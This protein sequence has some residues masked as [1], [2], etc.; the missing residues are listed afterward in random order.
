[1]DFCGVFCCCFVCF[2]F[3]FLFWFFY[4]FFTFDKLNKLSLIL[5]TWQQLI[6]ARILS[7]V[8]ATRWITLLTSDLFKVSPDR[9]H[10]SHLTPNIKL[11]TK[12]HIFCTKV[13]QL[14][15]HRMYLSFV[16]WI[17]TLFVCVYTLESLNKPNKIQFMV[18]YLHQT[19]CL[20][21]SPITFIHI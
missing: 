11:W 3:L 7:Q 6:Q 21:S 19:Y 5:N 4:F 12:Q 10:A 2:L 1:M 8:L 16:L 18:I 17:V 9:F 20:T 14:T 15:F 13:Y